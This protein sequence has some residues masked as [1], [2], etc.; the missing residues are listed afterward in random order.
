MSIS[1][2]GQITTPPVQQGKEIKSTIV[3]VTSTDIRIA[4]Q[5]FV[6]HSAQKE[7]I[8][9]QN[10]SIDELLKKIDLLQSKV[11]VQNNLVTEKD[12]EIQII[13]KTNSYEKTILNDQIK[14]EKKSKNKFKILTLLM[15]IGI[16]ATFVK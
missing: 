15:G 12:K 10:V 1:G 16:I 6:E 9:E 3:E 8:A 11:V 4:N 13:H 2:F 7:V 14:F 5:I